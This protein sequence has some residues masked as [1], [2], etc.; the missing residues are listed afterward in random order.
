MSDPLVIGLDVGGT[1]SRVVVTD[2]NGVR[3]GTGRGGGG[4]PVAHGAAAAASAIGTAIDAALAGVDPGRILAAVIGLAGGTQMRKALDEV[5]PD[6]GI[7]CPVRLVG[8][9][10]V[11]FAAGTA[12]PDGTVLIAGT[13]AIAGQIVDRRLGLISDGHGWLL[14][15]RGSG[16]WLGLHAVRA[17]LADL[18]EGIGTSLTSLIR[19]KLI[20][21]S[22]FGTRRELVS[23]MI[24]AAH[25]EPPV[26]L[27]RFAPLVLDAAAAGDPV[28]KNLITEAAGYLLRSTAAVRGPAETGPIALAGSLLTVATPLAQRVREELAAR[29][30]GAALV[31]ATDGAAGAA[32]LAALSL[33]P[34]APH[35]S[36]VR[37]TGS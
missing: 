30:P 27:S 28:A 25:A 34:S 14:G 5:W 21:Q 7:T 15:D 32:W 13:G 26:T 8:D 9:A 11:A 35:P 2:L 31:T 23:A 37:A 33:D 1:S 3:F 24:A 12:D 18:E 4:N 29:W 6:H 36:T 16:F 22:V 20:G 17:A 10:V 19:D